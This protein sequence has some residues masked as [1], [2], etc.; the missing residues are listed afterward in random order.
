[1]VTFRS[2]NN[3]GM[4][5]GARAMVW[6]MGNKDVSGEKLGLGDGG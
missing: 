4:M 3:G 6:W 1:M 2:N 5:R